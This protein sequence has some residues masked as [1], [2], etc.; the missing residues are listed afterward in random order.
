LTESAT[1]RFGEWTE[2]T[3]G[4][5]PAGLLIRLLG[6]LRESDRSL[7]NGSYSYS[8]QSS[9]PPSWLIQSAPDDAYCQ[10]LDTLQAQLKSLV[11]EVPTSTHF[12]DITQMG[13]QA[14]DDAFQA[15]LIA[16]FV[17]IAQAA[18]KRVVI[19]YLEGNG[20]GTGVEDSMTFIEHLKRS[21]N[22]L[23]SS[24]VFF[25]AVSFA[26]SWPTAPN[27]PGSWT[28]AK[29]FAIDG[30]TAVVGGQNDWRDYLPGNSPPHDVSIRVTGAATAAA[31][32]YANLLWRY[33]QKSPGLFH[34]RTWQL[35]APDY[36]QTLPPAFDGREYPP[37]PT[38][39]A[40]AVPILAVGNLGLWLPGELK[41]LQEETNAALTNPAKRVSPLNTYGALMEAENV[42]LDFPFSKFN[43]KTSLAT[44]SSTTARQLLFQAV[45]QD[46]H[47]RMSQQKIA[48]VDSVADGSQL[49]PWPGTFMTSL[50]SA[51]IKK[52]AGNTALHRGVLDAHLEHRHGAAQM[53]SASRDQTQTAASKKGSANVPLARVFRVS[54]S[55]QGSAVRAS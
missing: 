25:Y 31:H 30:I 35:G 13:N 8:D 51:M 17:A 12:I 52:R 24:N 46:G 11:E 28:H 38:P 53:R 50:V 15:N 49:L 55:A 16:S 2:V 41:A 27:L 37:P 18:R 10:F 45:A 4:G 32:A 22:G 34:H 23:A 39:P 47:L 43:A 21:Y 36:D 5:D 9:L 26:I 54:P 44:Q 1:P 42:L 7:E 6:V 14:I 3:S 20:A 48:D 29:L 19:R 33:V 40:S